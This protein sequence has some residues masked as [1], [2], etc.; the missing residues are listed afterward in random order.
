MLEQMSKI[1]L[2]MHQLPTNICWQG[3]DNIMHEWY[4]TMAL[5]EISEDD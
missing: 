2:I 5:E 4:R 1:E 3:Y